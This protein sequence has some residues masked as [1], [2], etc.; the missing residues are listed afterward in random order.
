MT[1]SAIGLDGFANNWG[2][3]AQDMAD[4]QDASHWVQGFDQRHL[5]KGYVT[6]SLPFGRNKRWLAN[7]SALAEQA[8]SGWE[9]GY[10]GSYGSG[11]PLGPVVST[12]QLPYYFSTQRANFMPGQSGYTV[13]NQF[14]GHLNLSNLSDSSNTDFNRNLF[15][16]TSAA[17][18]FG[19]TPY[20]FNHW[21]WNPGAA[22]EN[23]SA[24]KHFKFGPEDRLRATIAAQFFNVFNRHY[25]AAP[26]TNLNDTTFGQVTGTGGN[27]AG[28]SGNRIG[29]LSARFEW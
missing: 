27:L 4:I 29:Q 23:L 17:S 6:Y 1:G 10:Y 3:P 26:D 21:R 20:T 11:T 19:D 25:F 14:G 8:V 24:M 9:L 7:S 5:A 16:T 13:K 15:T 2:Y 18:P 28:V 12:Y 22:S